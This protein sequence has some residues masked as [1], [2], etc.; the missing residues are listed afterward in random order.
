MKNPKNRNKFLLASAAV[1]FTT[2]LLLQPAEAAV[3]NLYTFNDGTANDSV[4]GQNGTAINSPSISGGTVTFA[5]SGLNNNSG[6]NQYID[7]PNNLI[8]TA[9]SGGTG[10]SFSFSIWFTA[11]ESRDWATPL[12]FGTTDGGEDANSG[13]GASPYIQLIPDTGSGNTFRLTSHSA[14]GQENAVS[15]ADNDTAPLDTLINVVGVYDLS[16]AAGSQQS[17]YVDGVLI[18]S[19]DLPSG[20]DLNTFVNDN[21]WLGRG[22]WDGDAAWVGSIDEL[23]I[24]DDALTATDAANIFAAGP[25]AVPEP[26]AA[27][28]LLGAG[29]LAG[30]R[31]RRA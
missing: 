26:T 20:L 6:T 30:L 1:A 22:Q 2:P 4:G 19:S 12:S 27:A 17:Y 28:L 14:G 10:G 9:S 5:N 29:A 31:R 24:Y 25:V 23:A 11:T 13:A 16:A 7:L 18:G 3:V 15:R 8:S 21:N